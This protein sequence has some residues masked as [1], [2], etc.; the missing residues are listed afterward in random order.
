M[1][2]REMRENF[3]ISIRNQERTKELAKKRKK[4]LTLV[5]ST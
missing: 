2:L 5:T 1:N 3:H 4:Q